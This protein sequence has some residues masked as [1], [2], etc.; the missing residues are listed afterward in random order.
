MTITTASGLEWGVRHAASPDRTTHVDPRADEADA[1]RWHHALLFSGNRDALIVTRTDT[2]DWEP[3]FRDIPLGHGVCMMCTGIF[4]VVEVKALPSFVN[5][6][7]V[8]QH[9]YLLAVHK[10]NGTR[11]L[12]SRTKPVPW[13]DAAGLPC[14]EAM[15]DLDKGAALMHVWKQH[16]ERDASYARNNYP[17]RYFEHPLL[18]R[19][20]PRVACRHAAVVAGTFRDAVDRHGPDEVQ[21]LY[22]LALNADRARAK[23]EVVDA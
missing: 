8:R 6:H 19:L 2:G 9:P 13:L 3:V 21:R 18:T 1:R 5:R 11:C 16:W 23:R 14:W 17:A 4:R 10:L 7:G 12:G 15:S 20:E 22:D